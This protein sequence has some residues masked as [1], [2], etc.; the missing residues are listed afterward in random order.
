MTI[1]STDKHAVQL[2]NQERPMIAKKSDADA[3]LSE[4]RH[5][6]STAPLLGSSFFRLSIVRPPFVRPSFVLLSSFVRRGVHLLRSFEFKIVIR[7]NPS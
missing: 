2:C 1:F 5:P 7:G 4:I 3:Q 6:K